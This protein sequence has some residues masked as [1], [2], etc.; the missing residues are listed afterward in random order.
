MGLGTVL[1]LPSKPLFWETFLIMSG[2]G[3]YQETVLAQT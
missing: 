3:L 1:E 2:T